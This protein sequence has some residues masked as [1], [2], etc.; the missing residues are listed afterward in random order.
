[1]AQGDARPEAPVTVGPG[2]R[3]RIDLLLEVDDG[4]RP[5]LIV[6]E[7]KNTDWDARAPHRIRRNLARHARQVWRYLDA[8]L[9]RLDTGELAGVQAG[10]STPAAR[11]IQVGLWPSRRPSSAE[12]SP[13]CS[14]RS[15][16]AKA[17]RVA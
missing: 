7:I 11:H 10:W 3:G 8:L 13:C 5:L 15:S 4:R 6:V 2:R 16:T 9:P 14:T 17:D 12:A 1:M